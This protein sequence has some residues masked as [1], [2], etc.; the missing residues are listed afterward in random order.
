MNIYNFE[1]LKLKNN[2]R[3]GITGQIKEFTNNKIQFNN[4]MQE[5]PIL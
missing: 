5:I 1:H 4:L 2:T 3:G